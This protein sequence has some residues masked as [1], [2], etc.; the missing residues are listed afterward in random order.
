MGR[1][2]VGLYVGTNK[3]GSLTLERGYDGDDNYVRWTQGRRSYMLI[4]PVPSLAADRVVGG[5]AASDPC[6]RI[7]KVQGE[8]GKSRSS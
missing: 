3:G 5:R 6:N 4:G 8:R 7:I 1:C 2:R